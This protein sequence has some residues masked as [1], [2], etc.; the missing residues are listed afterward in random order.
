MPGWEFISVHAFMGEK[1]AFVQPENI[2]T[3]STQMRTSQTTRSGFHTSLHSE[4][5]HGKIYNAIR[6]A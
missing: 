5:G 6:A 4:I 3:V 1:K 2:P